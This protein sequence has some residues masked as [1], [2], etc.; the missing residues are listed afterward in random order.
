MSGLAVAAG[1]LVGG[2]VSSKLKHRRLI[3]RFML[4][5]NILAIIGL[6]GVMS[7]SCD[8]PKLELGGYL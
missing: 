6:L 5:T 2:I 1:N 4:L 7:I 3:S 8:I